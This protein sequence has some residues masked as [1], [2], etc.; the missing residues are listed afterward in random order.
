MLET[1]KKKN[2]ENETLLN[3]FLLLPVTQINVA[4]KYF[5]LCQQSTGVSV[6]I[7]DSKIIFNKFNLSQLSFVKAR[8]FEYFDRKLLH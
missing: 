5:D 2:F 3:F 7:I 1:L 4:K 6:M 8:D